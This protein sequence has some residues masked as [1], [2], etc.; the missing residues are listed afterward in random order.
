MSNKNNN[1][2]KINSLSHKIVYTLKLPYKG[3]H[4]TN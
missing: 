3:S 2:T 4:G 1:D